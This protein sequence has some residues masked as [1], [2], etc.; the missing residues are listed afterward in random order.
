[1]KW[2]SHIMIYNRTQQ[3][4][5]SDHE[6]S[7]DRLG[8]HW[9]SFIA[10]GSLAEFMAL[11]GRFVMALKEGQ[12]FKNPSLIQRFSNTRSSQN[13][14]ISYYNSTHKRK[15]IRRRG[16]CL[17]KIERLERGSIFMFINYSFSDLFD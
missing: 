4:M 9:S 1:M 6:I 2:S 16:F 15:Q 5:V 8:F 10:I 14:H 12:S 7:R 17:A 3:G 13:S 11:K